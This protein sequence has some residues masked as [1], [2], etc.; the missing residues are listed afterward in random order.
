[1]PVIIVVSFWFKIATYVMT[2]FYIK[3]TKHKE[4]YYYQ[5][6]GVS[7]T[8]LWVVSFIIDFFLFSILMYITYILYNA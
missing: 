4:F 5:A 1:M 6:L 8:I 7:K 2:L 3:Q